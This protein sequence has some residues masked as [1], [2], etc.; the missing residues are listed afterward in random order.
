MASLLRG[1]QAGINNDLSAGLAPELFMLDDLFRYGVNS[2]VSAL[3][4]D[5][6]QSLLAVGT[7]NS[8]YGPGQIY[9]F[10]RSRIQLVLPLPARGAAVKTLQFCADKLVCLDSKHELSLYSMLSQELL[11]SHTIYGTV[12][13]L[14]TDPALDYAFIGIQTGDVLAY[15]LDRENL[16]PFKIPNQWTQ[17]DPRAK[18]TPVVSLQ[19]HPR[20]VGTLLIGYAHGAAIYSFKLAKALKFYFYE[21]PPNAPGG[22]GNMN[23]SNLVRRPRL[24][25]ATWHPT[26]TFVMTGYEDSSIVFWDVNKDG[27]MLQARTRTDTDVM[28]PGPAATFESTLMGTS[29]VKEPLFKVA[30][31]ASGQDPDDTG[32]L[33]A[34]GAST[35][36]PTKG[37]CFLEFGRTPVYNTSSWEALAGHL[38]DPKR[39]RILP[40]P[41]GAEVVD[42]CLI[43][44][45]SPHFGNAHDPIAIIALLAS[46]ELLTLSF[47]S[48]MFISPTNQL[49]PSLTFVHPYIKKVGMATMERTRWLGMTETRQQGPPILRGG[50]EGTPTIRR[51]ETRNI[52]HTAHADG[53]VRLWDI[54]NGD[55]IE[56]EKV[57]QVDVARAVG[58]FDNVDIT[59]TSLAGASG[60]LAVGLR[61]GELVVF[62]W[63]RNKNAG[64]EPPSHAKN[65]PRSLVNVTERVEPALTEGLLP[66]TLLDQQAGAVTA[67]KMSEIGFVAA[68]FEDGTVAVIDLRGPAVIHVSSVNDFN[69]G[70]KRGTFRR[71]ASNEA[72]KPD[73]ATCMEFSVMTLEHEEWSSILLHVGTHQGHVGTFKII[74]DPSGRYAVQFA[75]SIS[76]DSRINHIFPISTDTGRSAVATQTGLASLRSGTRTN[77]AIV[78]VAPTS[79]HIARPATSKGAHKSFDTFFCDAAGIVQYHDKGHALVALTGDG[80]ARAYSIPA[81]KEI[82]QPM[83]LSATLDVR[84][85]SEAR[86]TP[87]GHIIAFTGP[88]ELAVLS[89]FG[90]GQ[91]LSTP[92]GLRLFNPEALIPPRPTIS[93]MQWVTGT[94]YITPSDLDLLIGGPNRP[95]SKRMLAQARADQLQQRSAAV[96]TARPGSSSA[97][98]LANEQDSG[99]WNYVQKQLAERTQKLGSVNDGM[100]SLEQT[101][102]NWLGDVNKFVGQQ[103]KNAVTGCKLNDVVGLRVLL[104]LLFFAV[105]KS[106]FGF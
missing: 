11:S 44:R 74:P 8:Q 36:A 14:T 19:L 66:F 87:T 85:F 43:P 56:N 26:G 50:V 104:T 20:D 24:T 6:V 101:T 58:R 96:A 47:P 91:L 105:I 53:A 29:S 1:K 90:T 41:P 10:G 97:A 68:G 2:Q 25:Q 48:G 99:Y 73:L 32:L 38:R 89:V 21:I 84:R 81:L 57:V 63:A 18:A 76:T 64:R 93:N 59:Q 70:E 52:I 80:F 69:R 35:Q 33:I 92:L 12:T 88:S 86:I 94:Q 77:G 79:V 100:D 37:L 39:S 45:S 62:R 4:Y 46:G 103:K 22:D 102:S 40:T 28:S 55:E 27:R 61:S 75:G 5:P 3:A 17:M 42:F 51:L 98:A 106:K 54:G 16:A 30:W 65:L 82:A 67:V 23:K 34:G 78:V 60:E 49:H 13:A 31:C 15:D 7:R 95:P 9:V 72:P 71:G 83:P